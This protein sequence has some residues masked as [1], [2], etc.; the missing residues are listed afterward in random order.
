MKD[1]I[2]VSDGTVDIDREMIGKLGAKIIPMIYIIDGEEHLFDPSEE[3]FDYKSFYEKVNAGVPVS[4]SQNPPTVFIDHFE[5]L[6]K[7]YKKVLYICFSSGLSGNYN[8]ACMA[9]EEVMNRHPEADIRVIDSLCA[10]VGEGFLLSAICEKRDEGADFEELAQ[11]AESIKR[12]VCHWFVVG[13][14]DQLRRGGRINALEAKLGSILN[15]HPILTTDR[16]GKLKVAEKVRGMRKALHELVGKFVTYAKAG[17]MHKVIV[18]H[19]G[20]S[21]LAEQL[22]GLLKE[23]GRIKECLIQDI[24]PVIGAHTG[25]PMCAVVF[26][27]TQEE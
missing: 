17:I 6:I 3:V 24:G 14:L 27:G 20:A 5:E 4:T 11:Y 18:A 9:A 13:N 25:S 26:M 2:V 19:A 15:I 8:S 22:K 23:T 1:Y 7:E 16:E 21:E 12:D 10:S